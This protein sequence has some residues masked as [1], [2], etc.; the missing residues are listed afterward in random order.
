MAVIYEGK[1][2]MEQAPRAFSRA[3]DSKTRDLQFES[4]WLICLGCLA[5]PQFLQSRVDQNQCDQ[6]KIAKCL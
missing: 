5:N 3:I 2:F 4:L 1:S 6:K